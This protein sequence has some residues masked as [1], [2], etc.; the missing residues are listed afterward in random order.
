MVKAMKAMKKGA[1]M[2]AMTQS[3]MFG[4][5]EKAAGVKKKDC[6]AVFGA[7][8]GLVV[9]ALKSHGKFVIPGVSMIKQAQEGD[10][11]GQEDGLWQGDQGEGEARVQGGEVLRPEGPEGRVLSVIRFASRCWRCSPPKLVQSRESLADA[12]PPGW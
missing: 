3:D 7:L 8:Q 11:C 6:K 10:A 1:A 2:R 9:S 4:A 5:L 12:V